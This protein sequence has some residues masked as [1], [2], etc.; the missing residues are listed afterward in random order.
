MCGLSVSRSQL[1]PLPLGITFPYAAF[2]EFGIAPPFSQQEWEAPKGTRLVSKTLAGSL[3]PHTPW[4]N[5]HNLRVASCSAP[6]NFTLGSCSSFPIRILPH[7]WTLSI[8]Q[9]WS[10]GCHAKWLSQTGSLWL[11]TMLSRAH[12]DG[13]ED[14]IHYPG[15]AWPDPPKTLSSWSSPFYLMSPL[16][17]MSSLAAKDTVWYSALHGVH[18]P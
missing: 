2:W 15:P 3:S 1:N 14:R 12:P 9:L 16:S 18:A 6:P 5:L 11:G 8:E 17:P 13:Y 10:W 7:L 4:H